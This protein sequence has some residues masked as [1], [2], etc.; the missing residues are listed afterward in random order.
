MHRRRL[1]AGLLLAG[2]AIT[3]VHASAA[4]PQLLGWA[5]YGAKVNYSG[6]RDPEQ[7]EAGCNDDRHRE[8]AAA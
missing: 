3:L 7:R 1:A 4:P 6:G 2:M 5:A 8:R